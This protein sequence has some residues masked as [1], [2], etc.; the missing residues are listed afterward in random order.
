VGLGG[1]VSAAIGDTQGQISQLQQDSA[2][3]AVPDAAPAQQA[4]TPDDSSS[5][6]TQD[7]PA[8]AEEA[9]NDAQIQNL[10]GQTAELQ[11]SPPGEMKQAEHEDE[12]QELRAQVV[13][14]ERPQKEQSQDQAQQEESSSSS[15]DSVSFAQDSNSYDTPMSSDRQQSLVDSLNFLQL[16]WRASAY[17]Q[18]ERK[19][20]R[21]LN[22]LAGLRHQIQRPERRPEEATSFLAIRSRTRRSGPKSFDWRSKDGL[23]WLEPVIAQGDCGSCYTIATVR[24]L[25]ARH[26]IMKNDAQAHAFSIMFPLYCS[27]YNQGCDGGYGFL[28]SKWSEDVGLVPESCAPFQDMPS[29]CKVSHK[30]NLGGSRYRAVNHHY[31]GG[32]YGGGDEESIRTELL[33]NGPIVMSFEPKEDFM[34]YKNGVYKSG[35]NKFHQEWE[36]VDHAVLLM[37]FGV[38]GVPY[39][40]L[41]NSWGNDWGEDGFFR[42]ARGIDESGCESIAVCADVVEEQENKV[43]DDFIS[44]L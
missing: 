11:V 25:S 6:A 43:L 16:G 27:E 5:L 8:E 14:S 9:K 29:K 1:S 42:M 12:E 20:P 34:Y 40:T 7:S 41:Q 17:P 31:V 35:P 18:F 36:Q 39:W 26:K 24:M 3:P 38:E 19:T 28:Q 32:Y 37:G 44:Q 33:Q 4:A 10:E 21:Q 23:N 13:G 2:Q 30:C 15:S 22:R